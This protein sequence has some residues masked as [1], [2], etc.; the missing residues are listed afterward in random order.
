MLFRF[1]LGVRMGSYWKPPF[2]GKFVEWE[3]SREGLNHVLE[4]ANEVRDDLL[5]EVTEHYY[6]A[7][8]PRGVEQITNDTNHRK[9]E[10]FKL[11][12][13]SCVILRQSLK[14]PEVTL[15]QVGKRLALAA[16]VSNFHIDDMLLFAEEL[17]AQNEGTSRRAWE[18]PQT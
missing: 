5:A 17:L 1:V 13:E 9:A 18:L 3:R 6:L 8:R 14:N 7:G 2:K 15:T 16:H 10:L 4:Q 11:I 12:C